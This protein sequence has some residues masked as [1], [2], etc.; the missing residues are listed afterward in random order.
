MGQK[1]NNLRSLFQKG[2]WHEK[3]YTVVDFGGCD[4]YQLCLPRMSSNSKKMCEKY[5]VMYSFSHPSI[6][7]LLAKVRVYFIRGK[8]TKF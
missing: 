2:H 1:G 5:F 4:N 3:K 7:M 6:Q 8:Y